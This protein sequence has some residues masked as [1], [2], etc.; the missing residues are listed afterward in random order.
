M[1]LLTTLLALT[2]PLSAHIGAPPEK[3]LAYGIY[4]GEEHGLH[5][6]D[7]EGYTTHIRFTDS[8]ASS[9]TI[10]WDEGNYPDFVTFSRAMKLLLNGEKVK[11]DTKNA[12]KNGRD[13]TMYTIGCKYKSYSRIGIKGSPSSLHLELVR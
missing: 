3:T 9:I 5:S 10:V 4:L 8:L 1:K 2:L 12:E 13:V 11:W 6:F 7:G